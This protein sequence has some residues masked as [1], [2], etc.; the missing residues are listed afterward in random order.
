MTDSHDKHAAIEQLVAGFAQNKI[1]LTEHYLAA[2]VDCFNRQEFYLAHDV[3]ELHWLDERKLS[4]HADL[5]KGIIQLAAAFVHL[6]LNYL[7]PTHRAHGRRLAPAIRLLKRSQEL[8]HDELV[9][10]ADFDLR[11][12]IGL[13]KKTLQQLETHTPTINPWTPEQSPQLKVPT[14]LTRIN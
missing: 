14:K 1:P 5:Y 8:M 6:K 9:K 7:H 13:S 4:S 10:Y 2:Y 3:L 12:M 11:E